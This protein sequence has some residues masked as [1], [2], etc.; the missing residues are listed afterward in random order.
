MAVS[1]K[2]QSRGWLA[3]VLALVVAVLILF[4]VWAVL[5]G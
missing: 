4:F 3:L 1:K 2:A 5:F